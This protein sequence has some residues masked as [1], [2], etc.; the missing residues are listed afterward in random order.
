VAGRVDVAVIGAGFAGLTAARELTRAGAS[1]VV[2]EARDRVGGRAHDR[3]LDDGTV[4]ELG[5]QWVGPTQRGILGLLEELGIGTEAT[6]TDGD[7]LTIVDGVRRRHRGELPDDLG[8]GVRPEIDAVFTTL[9]ALGRRVPL[10]A[11]WA[12]PDADRLDHTTMDA[13]LAANVE[14]DGARSFLLAVVESLFVR[15]PVETSVL[16]FLVHTRAAG[17]LT[18]AMSV[19][20]GTQ[21]ARIAGGPGAVTRRLADE[22][23]ERVALGSP[24]WRIRTARD[25]VAIETVAA[26]YTARRVIVA[27][28]PLIASRILVEPALPALRDGLAHRMPH[29]SVIKIQAVYHE[30]FWRRDGL[31]GTGFSTDGPVS[32]I[33]DGSPAD[34]HRGVL[35]GF[36]ES[37]RARALADADVERIRATAL[38]GLAAFVGDEARSPADIHVVDWSAD[39]WTRG[40]YSGHVAPGAWTA[41]GRALREPCGPIHWAGTET[42]VRMC[43]YMDGAVESGRRAAAEVLAALGSGALRP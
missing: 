1:C 8:P 32:Y 29:G 43:G 21:Q 11:P 41:F 12:A 34:G 16:D 33:A 19:E 42:A 26:S 23:G 35:V 38:D 5:G 15:P 3:V 14:H 28:A 9:D 2:L 7:A 10:D 31:A 39:P 40:C 18:E 36:I 4:L 20:G 25:G 6:P 22:L 24:V 37:R 30:P 13:W 27:M 17:S